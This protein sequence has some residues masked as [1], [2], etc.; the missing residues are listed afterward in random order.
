MIRWINLGNAILLKSLKD[1][2]RQLDLRPWGQWA[3]ML[4][5]SFLVLRKQIFSLLFCNF[6][7]FINYV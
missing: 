2:S 7:L 5:F 3:A 4:S 1:D 6:V